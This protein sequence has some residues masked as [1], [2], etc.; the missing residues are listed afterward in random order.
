MNKK[1]TL[2]IFGIV[3]L[4]GI[5]FGLNFSKNGPAT[6]IP[7]KAQYKSLDTGVVF[8]YRQDSDGYEIL[9]V[10]TS[11]IN[12]SEFVEGFTLMLKSDYESMKEMKNTEGPATINIAIYKNNKNLDAVSWID[13]NPLIS[14]KNLMVGDKSETVFGGVKAIR[15][16]VDGLYR[17]DTVVLSQGNFIYLF[18][19]A[20]PDESSVLRRDFSD[21]LNSVRFEK[22]PDQ[23]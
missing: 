16:T 15:Y 17:I 12:Q 21:L 2:V 8:D 3:V 4:V 22:T 9:P 23:I 6:E 14:N 7:L 10:R 20:Y 18:A 1:I 11:E 19:G 5:F 13:E